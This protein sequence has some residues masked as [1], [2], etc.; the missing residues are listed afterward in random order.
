[1]Y[2]V[3]KSDIKD[4][5]PLETQYTLLHPVTPC[6]TLRHTANKHAWMFWIILYNVHV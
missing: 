2:L 3:K 5:A 1:M 6:Y 4:L